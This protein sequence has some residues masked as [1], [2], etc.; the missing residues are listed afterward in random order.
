MFRRED[1]AKLLW[2]EV[3][4]RRQMKEQRKVLDERNRVALRRGCG[5]DRVSWIDSRA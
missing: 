5:V 1:I 4:V 2:S 3:V